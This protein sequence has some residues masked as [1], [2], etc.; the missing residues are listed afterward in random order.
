VKLEGVAS[1]L[2]V[3]SERKRYF[4]FGAWFLGL[5]KD[6]KTKIIRDKEDTRF[7]H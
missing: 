6:I 7:L 4:T 3:R 2:D 5:N 1:G